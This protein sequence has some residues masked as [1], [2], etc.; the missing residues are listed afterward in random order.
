MS[1]SVTPL[2][3]ERGRQMRAIL[4]H[5][6]AGGMSVDGA[7]EAFAAFLGVEREVVELA[8]AI[9]NEADRGATTAAIAARLEAVR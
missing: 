1:S 7:L 9:A 8:V 4:E 2:H 6:V 5:D 3:V